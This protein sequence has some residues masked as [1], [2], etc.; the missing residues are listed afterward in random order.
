MKRFAPARLIVGLVTFVIVIELC[1]R[2]DDL[3]TYRAP[4]LGSYTQEDMYGRDAIGKRGNPYARYRK[5]EFN[6]LGY[7]SPELDPTK[8]HIVCFGASETFGLYESDDNEYPRQL[9]RELNRA[10][11]GNKFQVI[12]VAN[13]GESTWM[14]VQRAPEI[15]Q[16]I[17]PAVAVIYPAPALYIYPPDRNRPPKADKGSFFDEWRLSDRLWTLTKQT[18]PDGVQK[19][20]RDWAIARSLR[21]R[22]AMDKLPQKNIDRY[23]SDVQDLA[24][25]LRKDGVEPVLVTHASVFGQV[26]TDHDRQLLTTWRRFYP[27]LK[28]RGFPDMEKRM[29]Q[30]V[31][32]LGQQE[33]IP[34]VEADRLIPPDQTYFAD[35]VHFTDAGAH[36]M[37]INIARSLEPM[38]AARQTASRPH[39]AF[40]Q[41]RYI[42]SPIQ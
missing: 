29:N 35:T 18:L 7:R 33:E 22:P 40:V 5:W 24:L 36:L 2:L 25:M 42:G 4:F 20:I 39:P 11:G 14:A 19:K 41:S 17:N 1:A 37:A 31:R 28:E 38:L 32:L 27:A 26:L 9:E 8:I 12:N 34:V 13:P 6:S 16:Q 10:V 15:V 30:A 23:R 3:V 21:G